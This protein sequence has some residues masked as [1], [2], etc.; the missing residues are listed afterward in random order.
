[1]EWRKHFG[2][3]G[4]LHSFSNFKALCI[5]DS[6]GAQAHELLTPSR[7]MMPTNFCPEDLTQKSFSRTT[8][9]AL[10]DTTYYYPLPGGAYIGL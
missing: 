10:S 9:T 5:L 1:M 6:L 8:T 3:A 2:L 4:I 7:D